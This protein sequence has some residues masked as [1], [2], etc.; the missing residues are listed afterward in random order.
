VA[1]QHCMVTEFPWRNPASFMVGY[2]KVD[3]ALSAYRAAHGYK[4]VEALALNDG[5][6]IIYM[7]PIVR[8]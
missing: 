7:Q 4:E 2:L 3:P 5:N 6:T 8:Q 1:A